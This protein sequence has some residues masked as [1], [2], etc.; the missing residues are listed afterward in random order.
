MILDLEHTPEV[1]E[2]IT[3]EIDTVEYY[4][5]MEAEYA[6]NDE[7]D[8]YMRALKDKIWSLP[9]HKRRIFLL[10]IDTGSYSEVARLM[11]CSAPT[12]SKYV[13]RLREEIGL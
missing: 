2:T 12:I 4:R 9:E 8:D 10:W 13:A 5:R 6:P 11:K 3:N 7:D 1:P